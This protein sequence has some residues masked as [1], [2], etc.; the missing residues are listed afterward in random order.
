MM[1]RLTVREREDLRQRLRMPMLRA[2]RPMV[3]STLWQLR[4]SACPP[5]SASACRQP[6]VQASSVAPRMSWWWCGSTTTVWKASAGAPPP[7]QLHAGVEGDC[8]TGLKVIRRSWR[9]VGRRRGGRVEGRATSARPQHMAARSREQ[10]RKEVAAAYAAFETPNGFW[11]CRSMYPIQFGGFGS[12]RSGYPHHTSSIRF[13]PYGLS[14][15][16]L[17][18]IQIHFQVD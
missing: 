12:Y 11:I 13:N 18:M 2:I 3:S 10:K 16:G 7:L 9:R 17:W 8:Q 14:L 15:F 6:A 4:R 1:A 5:A